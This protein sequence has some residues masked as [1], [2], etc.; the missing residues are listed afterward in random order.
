MSG[1]D[2]VVGFN[3]S[4]RGL[5]GRVNAELE[6]A[7]L[8]I[9]CGQTFHNQSAEARSSATT[10]RVEDEETL[11]TSASVSETADLVA[12]L[13]NEFFSNSVMAT[14]VVVGSILLASEE[15]FGM[16]E[17]LR[18]RFSDRST[19]THMLN[20]T[21]TICSS[22]HLVYYARFEINVNRSRHKL[23]VAGFCRVLRRYSK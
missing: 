8:A 22:L 4:R 16:E 5:R 6:L 14:S 20:Y 9:V 1:Q 3:N 7:L 11:E 15:S 12:G 10:E 23:A 13:V 21:D 19:H 17:R 18:W 2:R